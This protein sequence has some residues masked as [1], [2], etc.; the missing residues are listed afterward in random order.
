MQPKFG[1]G[2]Q[3]FTIAQKRGPG[4]GEPK[5]WN[6]QTP[7]IGAYDPDKGDK[8]TKPRVPE[9]IIMGKG[10][11]PAREQNHNFNPDV[12]PGAYDKHHTPFGAEA[13][14]FTMQ[15]KSRP[16]PIDRNENGPGAYNPDKAL[17]AIRTKSPDYKFSRGK[18][19]PETLGDQNDTA[20]PGAY[21]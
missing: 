13:G 1:E 21:Y 18:G 7:A 8:A 3:T 10:R 19:R 17:D 12:G 20:G 2:V 15:P 4:N 5:Q 14:G 16:E 11:D 6:D 9:A